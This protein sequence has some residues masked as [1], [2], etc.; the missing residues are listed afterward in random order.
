MNI[1]GTNCNIIPFQDAAQSLSREQKKWVE[2]GFPP[3]LAKSHPDCARFLFDSGLAFT[4]AMFHNT[5]GQESPIQQDTDSHPLLFMNGRLERW[6]YIKEQ[7]DYDPAQDSLIAKGNPAICYNYIFP[8]GIVQK[9]YA[10]Y[11][12]LYPVAELSQEKLVQLQT[13]AQ[14]FWQTNDE[15]DPAEHKEC[16]LQVV[17]TRRDAFGRNW[18]TENLL[19]NMPEHVYLRLV[20]KKG[21][22]YSFGMKMPPSEAGMVYAKIPFTY[23]T[24][25]A[26]NITTPDYEEKRKFD[27]RRVTS[28]PLTDARKDVILEYIKKT[29]GSEMCFNYAKQN[30]NKLAQVVL[31]MAGVQVNTRLTFSKLLG[32]LLPSPSRLPIVGLFFR[33]VHKVAAC[34]GSI[35][36]TIT[37]YIPKP[38]KRVYSQ[39]KDY[40]LFIP[41]TIMAVFSNTLGLIL[42][43]A[44][45]TATLAANYLHETHMDDT[46]LTY[47]PRLF[48]SFTDFF[49]HEKSHSYFSPLMVEWQLRQTSTHIY[50]YDKPMMY[51]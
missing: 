26:S 24:T 51:L 44:R 5:F 17:T 37:S 14:Q 16:V 8:E 9:H 49:S 4:I 46:R 12:T 25:A 31:G 30:C 50:A 45:K 2:L 19:D 10:K 33:T 32:R 1:C 6:E 48:N 22:V 41:R 42:G 36:A 47:F 43:G 28:I 11:D 34:V 23:L 38:V 40:L 13:H 35:F 3:E 21:K 18:F 15:V 7:I 20:D 27:E 29:N 39:I